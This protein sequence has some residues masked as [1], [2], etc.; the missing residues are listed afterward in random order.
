[1][2]RYARLVVEPDESQSAPSSSSET[3]PRTVFIIR[4]AEKPTGKYGGVNIYGKASNDSLIPRGWQRAGALARLFA[5]LH[6]TE[7]RPG[8]ALP[9]Q[10][11]APGY[12]GGSNDHRTYETIVPLAELIEGEIETSFQEGEEAKLAQMVSHPGIGVALISWEH[13]RI[14]KIAKSFLG[15][16]NPEAIPSEWPEE[17]FD[18][19]WSLKREAGYG[20]YVFTQVPQ[21]LLAGDSET[22][23]PPG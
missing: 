16:A 8:L 12:S 18:M 10:L 9:D 20:A 21:M 17:R 22:P 2:E 1:M 19:V 13:T 6:P 14:P 15:L 23:F 11:I 4:H 5:P 3:P 7:A